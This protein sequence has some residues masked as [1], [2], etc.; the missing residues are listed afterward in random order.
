MYFT[1]WVVCGVLMWCPW[2][3]LRVQARAGSSKLFLAGKICPSP[4]VPWL[5]AD[6]GCVSWGMPGS[7]VWFSLVLRFRA[8]F[9]SPGVCVC[10]PRSVLFN[11]ALVGSTAGGSGLFRELM[12]AYGVGSWPTA[13]LQSLLG[14]PCSF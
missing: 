13:E 6:S 9:C 5:W 12:D 2:G 3:G 11:S 1:D 8:W 14:L 4:T 10:V 7:G